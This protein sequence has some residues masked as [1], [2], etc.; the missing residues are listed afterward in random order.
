M[1]ETAPAFVSDTGTATTACGGRSQT[2]RV[3]T[4]D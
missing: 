2:F 3:N 1:R 4:R